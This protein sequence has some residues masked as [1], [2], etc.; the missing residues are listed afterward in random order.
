MPRYRL[1][2]VEGVRFLLTLL[3]QKRMLSVSLLE[4][5]LRKSAKLST[6]ESETFTHE[7][8]YCGYAL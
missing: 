2:S 8:V 3:G 7:F 4:V 1:L 6:L 5:G